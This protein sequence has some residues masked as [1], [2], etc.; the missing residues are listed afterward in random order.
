VSSQQHPYNLISRALELES[1]RIKEKCL[2]LFS[3]L[4]DEEKIKKVKN[5]FELNTRESLANAF[6]L[7]E[8]TV[9]REF[10]SV[11]TIVF[12]K[13][14]YAFMAARLKKYYQ[15]HGLSISAVA[16]SVLADKSRS[17]NDWT[18]ACVLYTGKKE[19]GLLK[20]AAVTPYLDSENMLI[21]EIAELV[22]IKS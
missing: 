4:Y 7:I 20:N 13:N 1:G 9:P 8:M 11:F 12:E 5:G 15:E 21:R 3:F 22:A 19:P 6:E 14:D 18:K 16:E 10:S 2:W 17:Y